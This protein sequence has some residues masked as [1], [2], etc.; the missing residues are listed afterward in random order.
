MSPA[1]GA[2]RDA[3]DANADEEEETGWD[4]EDTVEPRQRE[5]GIWRADR[6]G[7]EEG[8]AGGAKETGGSDWERTT[9]AEAEETGGTG[10]AVDK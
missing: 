3:T 4:Q 10:K 7:R 6:D 1:K 2:G 5:G 9:V 8:T